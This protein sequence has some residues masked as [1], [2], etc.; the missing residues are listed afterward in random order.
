MYPLFLE[1]SRK[2]FYLIQ[3]SVFSLSLI[4]VYKLVVAFSSSEVLVS[5]TVTVA[6]GV[7]QVPSSL[8]FFIQS[9]T[10]FRIDIRMQ[11]I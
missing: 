4:D 7:G 11:Y 5:F 9:Y 2:G 1:L 6:D 8:G 3:L 10:V